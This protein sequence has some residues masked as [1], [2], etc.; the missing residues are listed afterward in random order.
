[1]PDVVLVLSE[2]VLDL[3][4]ELKALRLED[5]VEDDDEDEAR[6]SLQTTR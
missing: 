1:V 5:E 3:V 6:P 4:L 2:A